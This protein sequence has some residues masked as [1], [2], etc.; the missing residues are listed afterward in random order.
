[1]WLEPFDVLDPAQWREVE[2]RGRTD[3]HVVDLEG[4]R[5]LTAHSRAGGSI[6]LHTVRFDPDIY[7]WLS[8]RWR[9]DQLVDGENLTRKE[10]SDAAA[11]VYVYFDTKGL[12]W[13]KRSLDYLWSASLPVGTVLQSAYSPASQIIVVESGTSSLGKWQAMERNIEDD[14]KRYFGEDP[15]DVIAIG[16]MSDTDNTRK[17]AVAYFDDVRVSRSTPRT[18]RPESGR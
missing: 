6:L 10:G 2:V 11:R 9:V 17:E 5:C 8:W 18:V 14:Y 7:E 3:Y 12:P 1:L 13:Q 15:P 4:R 16:L